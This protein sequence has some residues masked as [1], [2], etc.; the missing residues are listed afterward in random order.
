[1]ALVTSLEALAARWKSEAD[2]VEQRYGDG[3]TAKL[4]RTL[5]AEL[6]ETLREEADE[7]LTLA[8]AADASGYA[9]DTLRHRVSDGSIPNSGEPGRPRIRRGDVPTKSGTSNGTSDDE[10][11]AAAHSILSQ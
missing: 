6:T 8:E 9:S 5:A 4:L 7:L 1:M 11:E 10:V 3:T 2:T